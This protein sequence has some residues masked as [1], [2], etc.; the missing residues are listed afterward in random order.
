MNDLIDR[1][2]VINALDRIGGTGAEAESW[3][4]GWDKAID[5]A[6]K[7]VRN[8][9]MKRLCRGSPVKLIDA[10]ALEIAIMDTGIYPANV[11]RA[12]RKAPEAVVRCNDC[13]HRYENEVNVYVCEVLDFSCGD[14][15]FCSQGRRKETE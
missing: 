2:Q 14:D 13:I 7:I 4:D 10:N 8:M 11:R 1:E 6:I 12:I 15:D 9:P 5:E 3:A